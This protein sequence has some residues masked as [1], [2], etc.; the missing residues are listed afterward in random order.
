[1]YGAGTSCSVNGFQ[2]SYQPVVDFIR[3]F[4]TWDLIKQCGV[5]NSVKGLTQVEA[6]DDNIKIGGEDVRDWAKE[7]DYRCCW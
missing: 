7:V 6:D 1:M 2:K 3:Y 4:Q 5:P